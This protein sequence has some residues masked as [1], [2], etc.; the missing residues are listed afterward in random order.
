VAIFKLT[1]SQPVVFLLPDENDERSAASLAGILAEKNVPFH[2]FADEYD[3]ELA[4]F[5]DYILDDI[6]SSPSP[7]HVVIDC[8]LL[9]MPTPNTFL[10]EAMMAYPNLTLVSATPNFTATQLAS[11]LGIANTARLN[12]LPGIFSPA[13]IVE[14]TSSLSMSK[15]ALFQTEQFLR[16]LGLRLERIEDVVG[17]VIPRIV[18]MLA[19]EGAFAVMEGVSSAAEIDEAMRLGTN[20]PKGPLEWADSI[21]LDT[22]V[23]LLDA[24][25]TEYKQERYRACRL[26]RQYAAGGWIGERAGKGFYAY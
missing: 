19:N 5:A 6:A 4:P 9:P 1:D 24:L 7:P 10:V 3:E 14:F 20:Y 15:E 17:F 21:G 16:G 18:A 13:G 11:M 2:I 22:V 26:M 25:F 23:M 12:L 8:A